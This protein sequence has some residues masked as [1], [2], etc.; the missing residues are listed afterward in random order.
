L[1]SYAKAQKLSQDLQDDVT[2]YSLHAT[3]QMGI[4]SA[5]LATA[6]GARSDLELS[7]ESARSKTDSLTL[8]GIMPR[9]AYEAE[10]LATVDDEQFSAILAGERESGDLTKSA[11]MGAI[12]KPQEKFSDTIDWHAPHEYIEAARLVL[13]SIDLDPASSEAINK[14]IGAAVYY[15]AD[16]N[17]LLHDWQGRVWMNPPYSVRLI[18]RY[19]S[20]LTKHYQAGDVTEVVTLTNNSTETRWFYELAGVA[21]AMVFLKGRVRFNDIISK[22]KITPTRGQ[23]VSYLGSNPEKFLKAFSRF[24]WSVCLWREQ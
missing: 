1:K 2:E 12:S 20:K 3:R 18:H 11:V 19:I 10:T 7:A 4:I 6:Q 13:G 22:G 16:D 21:S 24:G 9:R 15:T 5:N 17:A 14:I 23:V 8:A